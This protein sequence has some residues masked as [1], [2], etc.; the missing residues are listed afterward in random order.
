MDDAWQLLGVPRGADAAAIR[1]A[2]AGLLKKTR[3]EDDPEAFRRLL[4][5]RDLALRVAR[6]TDAG[7]EPVRPLHGPEPVLVLLGEMPPAQVN[8]P[9]PALQVGS[10]APHQE[11]ARFPDGLAPELWSIEDRLELLRSTP[12]ADEATAGW[13]SVLAD[14]S[15]LGLRERRSV[16][17]AVILALAALLAP[18]AAPNGEFAA[19]AAAADEEYGWSASDR[20]V[21]DALGAG[22]ADAFKRRLKEARHIHRLDVAGC[23]ERLD[24][25]GLPVIDAADLESYFQKESRR[26]AA[27]LAKVRAEGRWRPSFDPQGLACGAFW[28]LTKRLHGSFLVSIALYGLALGVIGAYRSIGLDA[29]YSAAFLAIGVAI[30]V[31]FGFFGRN[32]RLRRLHRAVLEADRKLVFD[33]AQRAAWLKHAGRP[34]RWPVVIVSLILY[35]GAMENAKHLVAKNRPFTALWQQI[36]GYWTTAPERLVDLGDKERLTV[37]GHALELWGRAR[38]RAGDPAWPAGFEADIAVVEALLV[39][40]GRHKDYLL[41]L[42][43]LFS[44]P[45]D[46][47]V[48]DLVRERLQGAQRQPAATERPTCAPWRPAEAGNPFY[49]LDSLQP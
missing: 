8:P 26:Y 18:S 32:A 7:R 11:V 25:H 9:P 41:V 38:R 2:Y 14:L 49:P 13:R 42:Q 29:P 45:L 24:P 22:E 16:E 20:T 48:K 6:R 40:R 30:H 12:T 39:S 44:R 33:E 3:P 17:K 47:R 27:H 43:R 4:E 31:F 46:A 36:S 37:E 15:R 34:R 19:I 10:A 5:A 28:A 35:V 1:R 23:P 21:Y